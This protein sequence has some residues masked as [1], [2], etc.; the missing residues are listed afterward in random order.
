MKI[1]AQHT[2]VL[3]IGAGPS[4]LMMAAQLLRYGIQPLIIDS[5]QGPTTHSKALAVQARSMEIY[6][7]M[8]IAD[9]V[10]QEGRPA[11]GVEI[12]LYGEP[13]AQVRLDQ[14]EGA[15]TPYPYVL[16]YPQSRNERALLDYLT[17]NCCP[18]YWNTTFESISQTREQATVVLEADGES[19]TITADWVVAADGARSPV[20]KQLNISF[21][22][23][24]YK[25]LF[26]LIDGKLNIHF[27]SDLVRLFLSDKGLAGFF[28]LPGDPDYFRIVGSLPKQ[29]QDRE[30]ELSLEEVTPWLK[31]ITGQAFEVTDCRW[32]DTYKLHHRMAEHF[33]SGRCF[34]IGDAAHIHSP[35][36]GQGMNTGLQDA[37]NLAWKLAGVVNGQ[38]KP[39]VLDSYADE[40]MP[41]AKRLLNSTDRVFKFAMSSNPLSRFFKKHVMIRLLNYVW[42]KGGVRKLFFKTVSQTGI[43]YR[44]SK[45]SLHLSHAKSIKAGDRLP[46]LS[47]YDEKKQITTDLH[48]WCAKPGFT[49]ILMGKVIEEELFIVAKWLTQHYTGL[50]NFY[51]LPPSEKNQQVFDAF[52]INKGQHKS[53]LIRPDM[54]IGYLND[55]I[56]LDRMDRYLK[57]IF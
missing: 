53:M 34:L 23:D 37:Y 2:Q 10:K 15:D 4:G 1:T 46:C 33:R 19:Q 56:D 28:P 9:K 41:V 12:C 50:I 55:A 31:Q 42:D 26:Y 51:Y 14:V 3:I 27:D 16:M 30:D 24:T 6:R 7:Q 13:R 5:K 52:E 29:Y 11:M 49:L 21:G 18:V 45:L 22:G 25:N 40:R 48:E 43:N 47:I 35:V 32:I 39:R 57:E 8:G 44:D 38:S 54:H 17:Q 36:G 20:R